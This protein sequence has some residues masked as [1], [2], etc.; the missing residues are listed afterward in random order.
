MRRLKNFENKTRKSSGKHKKK[1]ITLL[2]QQG[3]SIEKIFEDDAI[4][5]AEILK[6]NYDI[7]IVHVQSDLVDKENRRRDE[8][9]EE[10]N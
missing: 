1:V 7:P 3:A 4:Q 8:N 2:L 10:E 6:G 5:I 9:G